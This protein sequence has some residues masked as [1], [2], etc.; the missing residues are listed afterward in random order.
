MNSISQKKKYSTQGIFNMKYL[1]FTLIVSF[2]QLTLAQSKDLK[3]ADEL[4]ESFNYSEAIRSYKKLLDDGQHAYYCTKR[5]A[6]SYSKLGDSSKALAWYEKCIDF[7]DFES[8]IYLRLGQELLKVGQQQEG[9]AYFQKYYRHKE[10]PHQLMSISF[11]EYYTDLMRDSARYKL[12]PLTINSPYDEFGPALYFDEMIFTSNRPLKGISKRRD[13]QTGQSFFNLFIVDKTSPKAELFSK[14]LQSKYNDGP[15][16]FS[17]DMLTAYIT[18]NTN[19]SKKHISTLDIF[20]SKMEGE[21]W[22]KDLRRLPIRKGNY[23]VAHAYL[24]PD[25]KNIYFASDMPGG[26]GGMDLYRCEIKNGFLT[27]PINLGPKIN[28]SGNEIFPFVDKTATLYFSSDMHPGLGGYD[29]FYSKMIGGEYTI[30][31]NLG[32]PINSQADDFSLILNPGSQLG[33][34]AS[35]REGGAGGDDIYAVQIVHPLDYCVIDAKVV[36]EEDNTELTNALIDITDTESGVN[37]S[38][39]TDRYGQFKCYLKKDKNY[40]FNV[41]RKFYADF[42]GVLTPAELQRYDILK[43]NIALKEK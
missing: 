19:S 24:S 40:S 39:K 11:L 14:E 27:Q 25:G 20:V 21:K 12:I 35:N 23:S 1:I 17:P 2:T 42:K 6:E 9:S 18:R 43:L 8:E 33:F 41:R 30:P 22:S 16:C 28:T 5:I 7:P 13:V 31:F 10:L 32:Y 29:L 15:L 34:F 37:M 3:K 38:I 4:F 36:S 26:Y